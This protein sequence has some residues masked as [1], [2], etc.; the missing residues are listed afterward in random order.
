M[1]VPFLRSTCSFLKNTDAL[2]GSG[3]LMKKAGYSLLLWCAAVP[4]M[5]DVKLPAIFTNGA[6]LQRDQPVNV[7]GWATA[8]QGVK[9]SFGKQEAQTKAAADGTW[10]VSLKAMPASAEGRPLKVQEV[11]GKEVTVQDVLVGEVWLASGQSNMEWSISA[12]QE[13]DKAA[14]TA[15][16]LPQVRMI[17]VPKKVTHARQDDFVGQ[18]DLA[19]PDKVTSFSAVGYF[20]ARQL[21]EQLKVPVGIINSSWGGTRIDPWLAEEGFAKVTELAD[22]AKTRASQLPGSPVFDHAMKQYLTKTRTWCDAMEKALAAGQPLPTPPA[23]IPT[24]PLQS[25]TGMYQAMI[26]PVRRYGIKGFI[27][28]QG[29]SNNGEGMLYYHKMR[30]LIDGWRQQFSTPQAPFLFVQLAPYTYNK[31]ALQEI[32]AAQQ[33]ALDIPNTGMAVINDIGNVK[34]IHPG[35]KSE[36]G[37]RLALWA[38][39]RTYGIKQKE[40]SGPLFREAKAEGKSMVVSFDHTGSG[41][42]ARDAKALTHFEVAAADGQFQPAVAT[43]AAD[44]KSLTVHSDKVT[45]PTQVRFA[46]SET[47]EPNLM[48]K[49]GLPAGAFHSQWGK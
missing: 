8:G 12:S 6:V 36:V 31:P 3:I 42:V 46:W 38:F 20:F 39:D 15:T 7:W 22:M 18:W 30:V 26:H 40:V 49:E 21:H 9:V 28:Y 47:A 11:G 45:A 14:A 34:N 13:A 43:I 27:W 32:W 33:K 37:R 29:E 4:A 5:A 2:C 1:E 17:K 24:L 41:L 10:S 35:N 48:N 19:T 23:A 44:G 16:P 25:Q